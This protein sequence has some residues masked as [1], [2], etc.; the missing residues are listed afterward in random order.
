MIKT[1]SI[2]TRT[3]SQIIEE[4]LNIC[5]GTCPDEFNKKLWQTVVLEK[6]D[7]VLK[8]DEDQGIG[9]PVTSAKV[10]IE[11][12][13]QGFFD[14][15][16]RLFLGSFGL[17]IVIPPV[18]GHVKIHSVKVDV[19]FGNRR[20]ERRKS[21]LA[22]TLYRLYRK[23]LEQALSTLKEKVPELNTHSIE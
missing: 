9:T 17:A 7:Y 11:R 15:L 23:D 19:I 20:I 1:H 12:I 16:L 22:R 21:V 8:R 2:F 13:P 10:R 5:A 14:K 3:A 18:H 6:R 4:V